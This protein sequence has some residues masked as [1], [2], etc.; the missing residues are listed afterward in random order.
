MDTITLSQPKYR[1][2]I[3]GAILWSIT[4]YWGWF[5]LGE[6]F[7]YA[8][9]SAGSA[10]SSYTS[11]VYVTPVTIIA[12]NGCTGGKNSSCNYTIKWSNGEEFYLQSSNAYAI[13]QTIY[14]SAWTNSNGKTY[15]RYGWSPVENK[16]PP[17]WLSKFFM[18]DNHVK[19]EKD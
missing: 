13:G 2:H 17:T 15:T 18:K 19:S 11:D 8:G 16:T 3:I 7:D 4:L 1:R 12:N 5:F 6:L 10:D 14:H 9:A